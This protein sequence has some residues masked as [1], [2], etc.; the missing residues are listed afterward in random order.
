[1][2]D[3]DRLQ[4]VIWNLISN[5]IKFTPRQGSV[6]IEV[7]QIDPHV[8]IRVRDTGIGIAPDFLP[9]VFDRFRQADSSSTRTHSGLGLGLAIVR[10]LVELHGGTVSAESPGKGKGATFTV[11]LPG[12]P[13]R[14][15]EERRTA[16]RRDPTRRPGEGS[17]PARWFTGAG[18]GR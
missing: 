15:K 16:S 6:S 17:G 10:H 9:Y 13:V 1:M 18:G 2:G 7:E 12:R 4:Q 11:K 8:Q 3:P 5:A 14:V